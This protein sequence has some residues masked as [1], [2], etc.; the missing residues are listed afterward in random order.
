MAAVMIGNVLMSV[1]R[2]RLLSRTILAALVADTLLLLPFFFTSNLFSKILPSG[3]TASLIILLMFSLLAQHLSK[4]YDRLRTAGL[5]KVQRLVL[6][7]LEPQEA[8]LLFARGRDLTP[9][10]K[11]LQS[12]FVLMRSGEFILVGGAALQVFFPIAVLLLILFASIKLFAVVLVFLLLYGLIFQSVNQPKNQAHKEQEERMKK[13]RSSW[14]YRWMGVAVRRELFFVQSARQKGKSPW[15]AATA[16]SNLGTFRYSSSLVLLSLCAFFI[17][18]EGLP[19]GYLLPISFFSQRLL[20]PAERMRQV[21]LIYRIFTFAAMTSYKPAISEDQTQ[22]NDCIDGIK[23]ISPFKLTKD[24]APLILSDSFELKSGQ[25]LAVT[26]ATGLG[27]SVLLESILS[28]YPLE[29]GRIEL[30]SRHK[31]PWG[32]IRYLNQKD[33]LGEHADASFYLTRLAHVEQ[34][35]QQCEGHLVVLDD[36]LMGMDGLARSRVLE[37]LQAAKQAGA[38]LVVSTNDRQLV[39]IA[40]KWISI[41]ESGEMQLRHAGGVA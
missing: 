36:P 39:S 9:N 28:M 37:L 34:I 18:E 4:S 32:F 30:I 19:T 13:I 29:Q 24:Q 27:K 22:R 25:L 16:A 21:S 26:G 40:D 33:L 14:F 23:F 31:M 15:S 17:I 1:L 7:L 12:I 8:L 20:M 35:L 3:N 41:Q 6:K 5:I 10:V 38:V 2:D 11:L